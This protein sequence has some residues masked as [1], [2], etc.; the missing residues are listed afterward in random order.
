MIF[1][2]L[3]LNFFGEGIPFCFLFIVRSLWHGVGGKYDGK[4][5]YDHDDK[6]YLIH[7]E[8]GL[9]RGPMVNDEYVCVLD[10]TLQLQLR[11]G[12]RKG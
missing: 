7:L 12:P 4:D 1:G 5:H 6:F 3:G 9:V 2:F 8:G 10:V 11:D